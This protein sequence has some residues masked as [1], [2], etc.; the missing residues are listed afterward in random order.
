MIICI[1]PR[2]KNPL[3]VQG[4]PSGGRYR[5]RTC[6]LVYVKDAL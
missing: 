2:N 1:G 5:I 6:H 4:D 3:R